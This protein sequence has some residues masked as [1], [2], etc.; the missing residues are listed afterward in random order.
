M[1]QIDILNIDATIKQQFNDELTN[2]H[3]DKIRLDD[4]NKTMNSIVTKNKGINNLVH[5]IQQLETHIINTE[6]KTIFNYYIIETAQLLEEYKKI[7]KTPMKLSFVGKPVRTNKVKN[8]VISDFISIAQRYSK[9][10][11]SIPNKDNIVICNNCDN[12]KL[13]DVIDNSVYICLLCGSQ[14]EVILHTSSYKDIDRINISSKYTYDRKVHFR[15]CINQYQGFITYLISILPFPIFFI[16]LNKK[17]L[18]YY[19]NILFFSFNY[20]FLN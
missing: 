13:F 11:I 4:L 10:N 16:F 9:I 8:K 20:M 7:L 2:L 17:Y 5:N 18:F 19:L 12:K 15:D 3:L 14:Q 6:N 1:S